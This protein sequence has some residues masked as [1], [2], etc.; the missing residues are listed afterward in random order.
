MATTTSTPISNNDPKEF[1]IYSI[2]STESMHCAVLLNG[3]LLL[4]LA[5]TGSQC[6]ILPQHFVQGLTFQSMMSKVTAFGNFP[7]RII[8]ER[9]CNIQY[10]SV[11]VSDRFL[12]VDIP[13]SLPLFSTDLCHELGILK[14]IAA[15]CDMSDRS[16]GA[17]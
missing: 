10:V 11:T 14:E 7:I 4:T 3:Q 15:V 13:D 8:G 5:D 6:D 9:T 17:F 12:V 16:Q 2:G 1:S